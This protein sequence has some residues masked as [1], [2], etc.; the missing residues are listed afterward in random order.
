MFCVNS[1]EELEQRFLKLVA[2]SVLPC[3][4]AFE[5]ATY[6]AFYYCRGK[7]L[8]DECFLNFWICVTLDI[9]ILWCHYEARKDP[10]Y[11]C[12]LK[13]DSKDH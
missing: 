1:D 5:L 4:A 8:S 2:W 13:I 3:L 11:I 6:Y 9:L 12:N 7:H 10:G